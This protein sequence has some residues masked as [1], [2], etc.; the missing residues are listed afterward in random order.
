MCKF[1]ARYKS[2]AG[3]EPYEV[4]NFHSEWKGTHMP[5][6][7][8]QR[9]PTKETL[10]IGCVI[11]KQKQI[12]FISCLVIVEPHKTNPR[13]I[14]FQSKWQQFMP[15]IS[16][17]SYKMIFKQRHQLPTRKRQNFGTKSMIEDYNAK[18]AKV[19]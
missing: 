9:L 16:V 11:I 18:Q 3:M 8:Q 7:R 4:R 14:T 15:R 17:S 1:Y 12:F 13:I 5:C 10:G 6:H 19:L 2:K